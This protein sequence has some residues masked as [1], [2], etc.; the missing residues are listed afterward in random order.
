LITQL[1]KKDNFVVSAFCL[2]A[3][4]PKLKRMVLSRL[5]ELEGV[6]YT[7]GNVWKSSFQPNYNHIKIRFV[8]P[9][10]TKRVTKG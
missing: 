9:D 8:A 5:N 4:K 6:P 3:A 2:A 10:M 1:I 7:V